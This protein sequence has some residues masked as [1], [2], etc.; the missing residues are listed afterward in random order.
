VQSDTSPPARN[1]ALAAAALRLRDLVARRAWLKTELEHALRTP[2]P[3]ETVDATTGA[4]SR[5]ALDERLLAAA[6]R[7]LRRGGSVGVLALDF[8]H[9]RIV[10]DGYGHEIGDQ[11][12]RAAARRLEKVVRPPHLLA[13]IGGD[14][15][16]VL[17]AAARPAA[18]RALGECCR[19]EIARAPFAVA[20]HTIP[21]DVSVGGACL[22]ADATYPDELV[23]VAERA[24]YDAKRAGR[25]C[26]RVGSTPPSHRDL[27]LPHS[28]ALD[29]LETL[30]DR[31]DR[32]QSEQEHSAAM[33]EVS[34]RLCETLGLSVDQRRRCLAAARLHDVGKVAIPR[35]ILTKPG[36]LTAAEWEIMRTHV[37]AGVDL[38]EVCPETRDVA[39]VVGDHHEREDGSGYPNGKPGGSISIEA[40]VIIVADAWTAMLADRP[41]RRGLAVH[42]AI[43]ELTDGRG[44]HFDPVVVDAMLGLIADEGFD[45]SL[46][47]AA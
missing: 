5:D 46:G 22:P 19:A 3:V 37:Q 7:A 45:S 39:G 35:S 16:V 10:N 6:E 31:L 43:Q 34:A 32:A 21:L 4:A 25:G 42:E 33:L 38:L 36:A 29:F 41:Y 44:S 2:G 40:K 47:L 11:V 18:L 15:F 28:G 23:H 13:R 12:L 14:E 1:S 26:V 9:F 30:A 20:G 27:P 8:D 24:L 17:A